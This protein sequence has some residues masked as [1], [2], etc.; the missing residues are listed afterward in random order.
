M[1]LLLSSCGSSSTSTP[2]LEPAMEAPTE[3][4]ST[5]V[6]SDEVASAEE[7]YDEGYYSVDDLVNM[8]YSENFTMKDIED[9]VATGE[10]SYEIYEEFLNMSDEELLSYYLSNN[11]E[12]DI[13]QSGPE[14][15]MVVYNGNTG[16]ISIQ[17]VNPENGE[18]NIISS[19]TFYQ[20]VT[21]NSDGRKWINQLSNIGC[22]GRAPLRGMFSKDYKY[23]A[24]TRMAEDTREFHAG[25]YDEENRFYDA[26]VA[27]DAVGGDF[28][29]PVIQISIG[30]T[31]DGH[32]VFAEL[33]EISY[34]SAYNTYNSEHINYIHI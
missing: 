25:Y 29:E 21:S 28:D 8:W 16:D 23:I 27:V 13:V 32:F 11:Q 9:K 22:S 6:T 18:K 3:E 10:I 30:F 14:I 5:G 12:F 33:P 17:S 19:F 1:L 15:I 20:R 31:E 34:W 4:M 24:M 2:A 7:V 26:T